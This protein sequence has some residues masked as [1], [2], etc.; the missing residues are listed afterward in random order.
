MADQP[1]IDVRTTPITGH[2]VRTLL[3]EIAH[4][5]FIGQLSVAEIDAFIQAGTI[6]FYYERQ[7]LLGFGAWTPLSDRWV[8]LGPIFI[9]HRGRGRGLGSLAFY[10]M[11]N[12]RAAEG[13]KL[14][15]ITKNPIIMHLFEKNGFKPVSMHHLP[16]PI[17]WHMI[18]R[19][20]VRRI[21]ALITK[22][23]P[24]ETVRHYIQE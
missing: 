10:S 20:N 17:K 13:Y 3:E 19:M 22:F 4:S 12:E 8:E 7:T 18:R 5:P 1:P 16:R 15:A 9:S 6:R 2:D 14:W 24:G 21:L 23:R 11:I